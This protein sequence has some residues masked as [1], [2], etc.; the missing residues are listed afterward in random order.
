MANEDEWYEI[1]EGEELEQGDFIMGVPI[2]MPEYT[3]DLT[4]QLPEA[5]VTRNIPGVLYRYNVIVMSQTCDLVQHKLKHVLVCS[6]WLL[7]ALG[8]KE[9]NLPNGPEGP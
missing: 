7:E 9:P 5:L 6:Y 4:E 3:S 2:F 8:Q 1:V